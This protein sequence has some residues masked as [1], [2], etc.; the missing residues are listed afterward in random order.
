[1]GTTANRSALGARLQITAV[2]RTGATQTFH[3]TVNT[4]GSFG[5]SSIQQEIGLGNAVR[6]QTLTIRWPNAAQTVQTFDNLTLNQHLRIV[7]G[8]TAVA[9]LDRPAVPLA[10]ER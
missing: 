6:I 5:A 10:T 3:R 4:G 1:V 9:V 2:D 8:D 7:E